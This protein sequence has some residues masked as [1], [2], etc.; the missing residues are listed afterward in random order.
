MP[1]NILQAADQSSLQRVLLHVN[2]A[3]VEKPRQDSTC[4]RG[5]GRPNGPWALGGGEI[6]NKTDSVLEERVGNLRC[7]HRPRSYTNS[8]W[9]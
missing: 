4:A 1:L 3:Q 9:W 5:E 6:K 8:F 2:S 7:R